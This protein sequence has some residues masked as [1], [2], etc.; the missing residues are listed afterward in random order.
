MLLF[1]S[2]HKYQ[3]HNLGSMN[4]NNSNWGR[5]IGWL[6]W[7]IG[8]GNTFILDIS[9]ITRGS[10]INSVG[11]NLG[12]AIRKGN[13]VLSSSVVSVAVLVVG[14]LGSSMVL[15][16]LDT[17]A[18]L[19]GWWVNWLRLGIGRGRPVSWSRDGN[20]NWGRG[21]D[22]FFQSNSHRCWCV[23]KNRWSTDK[24]KWSNRSGSHSDQRS[25]SSYNRSV[26]MGVSM[27]MGS[28]SEGSSHQAGE[29]DEGLKYK[30]RGL[31][32]LQSVKVVF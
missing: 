25:W 24:G 15:I 18:K 21:Q 31:F 22:W 29:N 6:W 27:S 28:I 19:V 17:V 3:H 14:V 9:N 13:S 2:S 16:S 5:S 10:I 4:R 11:H 32:S 26:S 7:L 8:D 30:R 20:W 12:A 1:Y 23:S